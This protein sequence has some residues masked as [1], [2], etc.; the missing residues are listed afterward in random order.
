MI[1]TTWF[2]NIYSNILIYIFKKFYIFMLNLFQS[3]YILSRNLFHMMFGPG[4]FIIFN[5][6]F[7]S[8]FYVSPNHGGLDPWV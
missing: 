6:L 3:F 8:T 5:K 4:T 1:K 2:L 7:F